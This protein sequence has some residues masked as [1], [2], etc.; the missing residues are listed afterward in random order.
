MEAALE[1]NLRLGLTKLARRVGNLRLASRLLSGLGED[2]AGG[3]ATAEWMQYESVLLQQA[4]GESGAALEVLWEG[5]RPLLAMGGGG[6][7][8]GVGGGGGGGVGGGG[9]GGGGGGGGNLVRCKM[10]LKLAGWLQDRA[11]PRHAGATSLDSD[12]TA[13]LHSWTTDEGRDLVRTLNGGRDNGGARGDSR[14]G[15][16]GGSGGGSG[17]GGGG[18]GSGGSASASVDLVAGA[19]LQSATRQAPRHAKAQLRWGHWCYRQGC[20]QLETQP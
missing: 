18:G 13:E 14:G 20:A 16:S 17:G 15:G 5:C 2:G 1:V 10:L 11:S 12:L 4:R 6:G 8:G 3:G 9:V 7:G 19:C